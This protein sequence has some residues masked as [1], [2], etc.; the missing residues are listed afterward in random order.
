MRDVMLEIAGA[1]AILGGLVHGILGETKVFP[2]T[3]IEPRWA[4][5]LIRAVWHASAVA[6]I[7]GGV[8]LIATPSFAANGNARRWI[9][10]ALAVTYASAAVGNALAT[11]GRHFGWIVLLAVVALALAGM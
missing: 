4:R 10:A 6:W 3:Q 9:V 2:R 8:L 5:R 1:L 7:A 11:R